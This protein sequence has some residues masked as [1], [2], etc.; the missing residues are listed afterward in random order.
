MPSRVVRNALN[1]LGRVK[2]NSAAD[3]Y[4]LSLLLGTSYRTTLRHLSNLKLA[5]RASITKWATVA[6]S[7]LKNQLDES[8]TSTRSRRAEVY[9]ITEGYGGLNLSLEPGDRLIV[10]SDLF[11]SMALPEFI[12]EVGTSNLGSLLEVGGVIEDQSI[13]SIHNAV[14]FSLQLS[15][16]EAPQGLDPRSLQ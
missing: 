11:A 16:S 14:G 3:V 5:P 2:P 15:V 4:Q 10:P 6:P 7:T 8:A 1:V 13:G 12:D 9:R